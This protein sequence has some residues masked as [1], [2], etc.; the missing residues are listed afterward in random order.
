MKLASEQMQLYFARLIYID[1]GA[2]NKKR[3]GNETLY[4]EQIVD[5]SCSVRN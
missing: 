1:D 3:Q 2:D 4:H 5:V